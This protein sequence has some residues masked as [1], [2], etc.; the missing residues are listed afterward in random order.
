MSSRNKSTYEEISRVCVT[1]SWFYNSFHNWWWHLHQNVNRGS[2]IRSQCAKSGLRLYVMPCYHVTCECFMYC[3]D[4]LFK[5]SIEFYCVVISYK[6]QNSTFVNKMTVGNEIMRYIN[7]LGYE[8]TVNKRYISRR[9]ASFKLVFIALICTSFHLQ[10]LILLLSVHAWWSII[11]VLPSVQFIPCNKHATTSD[12]DH[13]PY[14]DYISYHE[15]KNIQAD[16][17]VAFIHITC[18]QYRNINH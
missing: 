18:F 14:I 8:Y 10:V 13:V 2:E 7:T 3:H 15:R 16:L 6:R 1:L 5:R 4:E 12:H 17:S 9:R 11:R